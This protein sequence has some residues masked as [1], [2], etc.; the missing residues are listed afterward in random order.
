MKQNIGL[1]FAVLSTIISI[2]L[3]TCGYIY[4]D[5][6]T[7]FWGFN[8][9]AL[10][11]SFQDY[12]IHGG[13]NNIL[14]LFVILVVFIA[15]SL[16]NAL[17]EKDL[18]G[19]F[20]KVIL[21]FVFGIFIF[22]YK[23]SIKYILKAILKVLKTFKKLIFRYKPVLN[24]FAWIGKNLT[25]FLKDLVKK[26]GP[27]IVDTVEQSKKAVKW[28]NTKDA[29]NIEAAQKDLM[30]HYFYL[31]IFYLTFLFL[32]FYI[33]NERKVGSEEAAKHFNGVASKQII[34]K[35]DLLN[36][37]LKIK[38]F[39]VNYPIKAKVLLCGSNKCLIAIPSINVKN[40]N[41]VSIPSTN[42]YFIMTIESNNYIILK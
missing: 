42:N 32:L 16:I 10:G 3:F 12:L 37:W 24:C 15:V 6:Y 27:S 33:V 18:Y 2:F 8:H 25:L 41:S 39:Q 7:H 20:Y 5:S 11:F 13:A 9:S 4:L 30:S 31:V 36:E 38:N 17:R 1:D 23:I 35:S 40:I 34:F 19:S 22:L 28:D 21:G 26:V 29:V 14:S